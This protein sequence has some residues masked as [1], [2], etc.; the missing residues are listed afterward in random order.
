MPKIAT[1]A[2][3]RLVG[4]LGTLADELDLSAMESLRTWNWGISSHY[5]K[6]RYPWALDQILKLQ[7]FC[8]LLTLPLL[9][10]LKPWKIFS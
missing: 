5:E 10:L 4:S 2:M 7:K 1:P 8:I 3:S 9:D 6:D